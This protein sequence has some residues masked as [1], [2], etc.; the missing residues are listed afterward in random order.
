MAPIRQALLPLHPAEGSQT[1]FSPFTLHRPVR[2]HLLRPS[3]IHNT[4][5]QLACADPRDSLM[6]YLPEA[7]WLLQ[8]AFSHQA[9]HELAQSIYKMSVQIHRVSIVGGHAYNLS[10]SLEFLSP[11]HTLSP[12]RDISGGDL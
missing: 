4:M 2:C 7:S 11:H 1:L 5:R 9:I 3:C 12:H 6:A 8:R 10:H